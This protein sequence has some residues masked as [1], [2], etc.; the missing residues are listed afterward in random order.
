MID[1]LKRFLGIHN[2]GKSNNE[3]KIDFSDISNISE[4]NKKTLMDLIAAYE[5]STRDIRKFYKQ[6]E[7]IKNTYIAEIIL[8]Q[9]IYD[10]ITPDE[11]S[12][13]VISISPT[14]DDR[15]VKEALDELQERVNIDQLVMDIIDDLISYGEYAVKPIVE[16]GKGIVDIEDTKPG[17]VISFYRNQDLMFHV[18]IDPDTGKYYL[19]EPGEYVKFYV[20]SKRIRLELPGEL[21]RYIRERKGIDIPRYVRLGS[22]LFTPG[23]IKKIK[24]LNLLED[25]IPAIQIQ[26]MRKS[27]VLG[28]YV[29]PS[30]PPKEALEFARKLEEKINDIGIG[31]NTNIEHIT[32]TDILRSATYKKV[33]P[34][35]SEKGQVTEIHD[36]KRDV[37]DILEP[38]ENLREVILSSVGIPPE[39]IFNTSRSESRR[40]EILKRYSRYFRKLKFIQMSILEG[41][42]DLVRIHLVNR[43]VTSDDFVVRFNNSLINVDDL[44]KLEFQQATVQILSDIKK[45]VD[46]ISSDEFYKDYIDREQFIIYMNNELS[47]VGL[48]PI[49]KLPGE[50]EYDDSGAL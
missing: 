32:V 7:E 35:T 48:D 12:S 11:S 25:L 4:I 26:S 41:I 37:F 21:V 3:S 10:V 27:S 20:S 17:E 28:V 50:E 6:I 5:S 34:V 22:P 9:I 23:R 31:V 13:S 16:E 8:E 49:L 44:D 47:K 2:E 15:E 33:I 46:E 40:A 14:T 19:H 39:L 45:F 24:Q 43:G 38:I 1:I 18:R 29:P 36:P 42:R 30:M